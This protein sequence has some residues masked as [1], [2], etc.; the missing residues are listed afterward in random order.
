MS[1]SLALTPGLSSDSMCMISVSN[2]ESDSES[3][4]VEGASDFASPVFV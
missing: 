1:I 4:S 3:K 2:L